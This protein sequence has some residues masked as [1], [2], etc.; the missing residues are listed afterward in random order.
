MG[1]IWQSD[2]A[3]LIVIVLVAAVCLVAIGFAV[4]PDWFDDLQWRS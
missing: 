2:K 4:F 3:M 1:D